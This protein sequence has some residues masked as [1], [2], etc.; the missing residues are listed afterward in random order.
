MRRVPFVLSE[1][2]I[3]PKSTGVYYNPEI[4]A[5]QVTNAN[6]KV[7]FYSDHSQTMPPTITADNLEY[8]RTYPT[9]ELRFRVPTLLTDFSDLADH[10]VV[11]TTEKAKWDK[12]V[13]G[14]IEDTS[15]LRPAIDRSGEYEANPTIRMPHIPLPSEYVPSSRKINGREL[16][17]DLVF[18]T[19]TTYTAGNTGISINATNSTIS[20]YQPN[21]TY[22]QGTLNLFN[23]DSFTVIEGISLDEFGHVTQITS[24][25][26]TV[27]V[28]GASELFIIPDITSLTIR[29]G[30]NKTI[31][32]V[33]KPN[34]TV[35]VVGATGICSATVTS[36]D[37]VTGIHKITCVGLTNMRAGTGSVAI[38]AKEGAT[39]KTATI[40][41]TGNPIDPLTITSISP[42]SI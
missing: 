31:S 24:K 26:Y 18:D 36:S 3:S 11:S 14:V 25:T 35:S 23:G 22:S 41:V 29:D 5:L 6:I 39:T 37:L 16:T 20:H 8:E 2:V 4:N 9:Q 15:I 42:S 38:T 33:T 40:S 32:V 10:G 28:G 34:A 17:E 13:Q 7:S 21:I 30:E 12:A 1:G 19:G 27:A